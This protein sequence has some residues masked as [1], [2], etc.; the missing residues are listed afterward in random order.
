MVTCMNLHKL[1]IIT[2]CKLQTILL[3]KLNGDNDDDKDC[4]YENK[5]I[6]R[7]I[8]LAMVICMGLLKICEK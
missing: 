1:Y 6:F 8:N 4:L 7:L 5:S 2:V 3:F